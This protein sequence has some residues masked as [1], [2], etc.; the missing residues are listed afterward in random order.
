MTEWLPIESAPKEERV[1]LKRETETKQI[2][3]GKLT[4]GEIGDGEH[5]QTDC[6]GFVYPT[7]THWMPL[8][9]KSMKKHC[10]YAIEGRPEFKCV[11][12]TDTNEYFDLVWI[13]G[14]RLLVPYCPFCGEKADE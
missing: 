3:I 9:K 13:D 11:S 1:L 10:C 7:P 6:G 14:S 5:W 4:Y 8:P 2:I 12:L